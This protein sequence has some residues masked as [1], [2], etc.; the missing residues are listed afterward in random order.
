MFG[1]P[2]AIMGGDRKRDNSYNVY[3]GSVGVSLQRN[4]RVRLRYYW[5]GLKVLPCRIHKPYSMM[6]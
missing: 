1:R 3:V 4:R 2:G 6:R 5:S